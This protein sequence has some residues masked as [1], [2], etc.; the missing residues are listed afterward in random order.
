MK[1]LT[2]YLR[3]K[4]L[5]KGMTIEDIAKSIGTTASTYSNKERGITQFKLDELKKMCVELDISNDELSKYF[6]QNNRQNNNSKK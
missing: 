1:N 5:D 3:H 6:L 4:R 2:L